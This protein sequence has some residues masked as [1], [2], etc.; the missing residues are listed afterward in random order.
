MSTTI[1][2]LLVSVRV[3]LTGNRA[4]ILSLRE[5]ERQFR[6]T[7]Q[8]AQRTDGAITNIGRNGGLQHQAGQ[9]LQLLNQVGHTN[10]GLHIMH[11]LLSKIGGLGPTLAVV[12]GAI[13]G[14]AAFKLSEEVAELEKKRVQQD[15]LF[16][17]TPTGGPGMRK[18]AD[19]L[20]QE[21]GRSVDGLTDAIT[22]FKLQS[23]DIN[24]KFLPAMMAGAE[25][26]GR[27]LK[28][29]ALMVDDA[30]AGQGKRLKE[31]G[32][33]QLTG[34]NGYT[35]RKFGMKTQTFGKEDREGMIDYLGKA[36]EQQYGG[37]AKAAADTISGDMTRVRNSLVEGS[38]SLWK[39]FAKGATDPIYDAWHNIANR[40]SEWLKDPSV[41]AA[42]VNIGRGIGEAIYL[43]G[44]AV[45]LIGVV[46]GKLTP[47]L[48]V[49]FTALGILWDI[50]GGGIKYITALLTGQ[51]AESVKIWDEWGETIYLSLQLI[52]LKFV[53]GVLDLIELWVPGMDEAREATTNFFV[54]LSEGFGGATGDIDDMFTEFKRAT[55]A[56]EVEFMQWIEGLLGQF[57]TLLETKWNEAG[58]FVSSTIDNIEESVTS[59]LVGFSNGITGVFTDIITWLKDAFSFFTDTSNIPVMTGGRGGGVVSNTN[60]NANYS[61]TA[62]TVEAGMASA[63]INTSYLYG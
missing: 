59:L 44:K 31:Y 43:I 46:I 24:E 1:D 36:F 4:A 45:E 26:Q 56:A 3:A 6:N 22:S 7:T 37:L 58:A 50:F 57:F 40:I 9:A 19:E 38:T 30:L 14:M 13:A 23:I 32:I 55:L 34:P 33:S 16:S 2:E 20:G 49:L 48:D 51:F 53:N 25:S 27:T 15:F 52:V 18:R 17:D 47:V 29:V 42:L 21:F 12:A 61:I 60:V 5:L 54:W 62:P 10:S 63:R 8:A 11:T 35:F 41:Q 39:T 28:S